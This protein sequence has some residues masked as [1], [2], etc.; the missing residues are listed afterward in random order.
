MRDLLTRVAILIVATFVLVAANASAAAPYQTKVTLS[1][2][3]PT[4]HGKVLSTVTS[5]MGSAVA[6]EGD[7]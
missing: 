3:P 4:W 6:S 7:S 1:S 5:S 2:Q